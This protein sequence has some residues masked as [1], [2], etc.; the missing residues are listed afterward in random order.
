[1][2]YVVVLVIGMCMYFEE[3]SLFIEIET[4]GVTVNFLAWSIYRIAG[5][6]GKLALSRY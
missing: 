2:L 1:M 4:E 5:K 6:F 3:L